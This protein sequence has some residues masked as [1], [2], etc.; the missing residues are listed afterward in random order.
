MVHEGVV[1]AGRGYLYAIDAATG[2]KLW[3]FEE[4]GRHHSA[5]LISGGRIFAISP[6]VEFSGTSRV[7][8][9]YLYALDAKTG[10]P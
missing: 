10:K 3:S 8:Q 5:Q 7:D 4:I 1:Y 6:T 2:T 9:G